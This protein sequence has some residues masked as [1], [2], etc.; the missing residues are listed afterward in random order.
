MATI[1]PTPFF[2]CRFV[3]IS[4]RRKHPDA[5]DNALWRGRW[6]I[7]DEDWLSENWNSASTFADVQFHAANGA[8]TFADVLFH[9]ENGAPTFADVLFH[10]E[11]GVPTFADVLFHAE[12]GAPTFAD[13]L[14]H[15]ENGAS[16]FVDV[17]F[18]T[19]NGA[20]TFVDVLFRTE[21]GAPTFADT[22]FR[23]GIVDSF[24][25]FL[26][27]WCLK[28]EGA[29]HTMPRLRFLRIERERTEVLCF[30]VGNGQ[31]ISGQDRINRRWKCKINKKKGSKTSKNRL[32]RA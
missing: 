7:C 28:T 20:S 25:F 29:A 19:E 3:N 13:V 30:D 6:R 4:N 10:A 32:Y 24:R 5:R 23:F 21:N 12:N 17:L 31:V 18:H 15:A 22:P 9:A 11:N 14:F 27:F 2:Y 1:S 26:Y 16:T 8:S